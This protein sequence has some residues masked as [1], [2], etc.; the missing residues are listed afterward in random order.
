[1]PLRIDPKSLAAAL[2]C[3]NFTFPLAH[4]P[5]KSDPVWV[6]PP[7]RDSL[8]VPMPPLLPQIRRAFTLIELLLVIAIIAILVS[9]TIPA[10]SSSRETARRIKC[11]ANLKGI[12]GGISGYMNDSKDLLP[13][14]R[15]L[16]ASGGN[17]N[18]PSLLDVMVVYLSVNAPER[19]DE[20]NPNSN[21][22]H[23]S[24]VFICPADR[25]GKDP[26][27][28]Y[29]PLWRTSGTSYEYLAGEMMVFAEQLTVP[30]PQGAV[31]E[32]FKDPKWRDLPVVLDNDDWH[33]LRRGQVPR[34][35]LFFGDWHSD[36]AGSVV[37]FDSQDPRLLRLVCDL[38]VT[39]GRRLFPG[40][41]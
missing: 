5:I 13:R 25:I 22:I 24:D 23:V 11:L 2:L 15:P 41:N 30:D 3:H 12:G 17:T 7:P 6:D 10:L 31:T 19:E 39:Y 34:N 21:F 38:V 9:I 35:G 28:N 32:V 20:A 18:D 29:E 1:M 40:C 4:P 36:W 8:S 33:T 16:H 14:V 37:R 26:A 27:T